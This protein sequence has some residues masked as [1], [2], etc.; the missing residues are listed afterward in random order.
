LPLAIVPAGST[1]IIARSLR[2]P[3]DARAA[4]RLVWGANRLRTIDAGVSGK[5]TFLHMAGAGVDSLLFELSRPELKR[6]IGWMAYVPAALSALRR[7]LSTY[8]VRS[9]E[10]SLEAVRSPLVLVANGAAIIAPRLRVDRDIAVDDGWLDVFVVTATTP[11]EIATVLARIAMQR[12]RGTPHV[13]A[14]RTRAVEI[15][16]EPGMCVQFDGDVSGATPVSISLAPAA[17][18]VVVPAG[19]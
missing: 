2:I 1:N 17:V 14:W 18:Q 16:A 10:R 11:R 4:I 13:Q 8:T 7:P 15:S 12:L 19:K 9:D 6:R 5:T 3:K